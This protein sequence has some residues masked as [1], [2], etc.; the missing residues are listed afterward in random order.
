[1]YTA[2]DL[3]LLNRP[4]IRFKSRLAAQRSP[5]PR[6]SYSNLGGLLQNQTLKDKQG[7]AGGG[8]PVGRRGRQSPP[9]RLGLNRSR[10]GRSPTVSS[11]NQE[12][13]DKMHRHQRGRSWDNDTVDPESET[14]LKHFCNRNR[15]MYRVT[16][17]VS[18]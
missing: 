2:Y 10:G 12:M 8:G 1:M 13:Q 9:H 6:R 16:M 4:P 15:N 18:N 17:V 5:S 7:I 14:I 3:R 11:N